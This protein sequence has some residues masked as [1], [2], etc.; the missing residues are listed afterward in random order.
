MIRV[1][2]I[3]AKVWLSVGIFAAG[4]LISIAIGQL[5]GFANERRLRTTAVALF[6]A[7]Q[8]SQEAAESFA[9]MVRNFNDAI[10]TENESA[11]DLASQ[12]AQQTVDSLRLVAGLD[13]VDPERR[14]TLLALASTLDN[15]ARNGRSTYGDMLRAKGNLTPDLQQRS[16]DVAAQVETAKQ[17]FERLAR[18]TS[19]DL[20]GELQ[21]IEANSIWQRNFNLGLLAFTLL[22]SGFFVH[23]TIERS[24]IGPVARIID[25]V[26]IAASEAALASDQ[27]AKS[28]GLVSHSANEQA[29]YLV[30]TSNSLTQIAAMTRDNAERSGEADR[31]MGDVRQQV[32]GATKTMQ[33]L[34][35]AMK[36]IS[37]ATSEVAGILKSIEEIAFLTNILALNA[38]VEA[39]RAG[40]AGVGFNVVADEVRSLAR[41]SSD[42]AKN[43]AELIEGTLTKV[44]GG[45]EMVR[46]S[47]EAFS[48][49]VSGILSG[50]EVVSQIAKASAEQRRAI[51][52]ISE[53][54]SKMDRVTQNNAATAEET[55][56]AAANMSQQVHTTRNFIDELAAVVGTRASA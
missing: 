2:G 47:G 9:R 13:G 24:V 41:R 55:A 20:E 52:Q 33:Q 11:L 4:Y 36:D 54:V 37:S 28:G 46:R 45:T 43:T 23:R 42:A 25:G 19:K 49:I 7:A 53:A 6:P 17:G 15:V 10:M 3:A 16:R 5:Q 14:A 30:D 22:V 1:N 38:A 18:Q 48:S 27:V 51:D 56:A 34:T 50:S 29:S 21:T 26:T 35:V 31:V 12:E 40:E 39:A 32:E 8:R 44:N